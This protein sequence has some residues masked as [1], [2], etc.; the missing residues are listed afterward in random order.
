VL[1]LGQFVGVCV[2]E[3]V[4]CAGEFWGLNGVSVC[5]VWENLVWVCGSEC[6]LCEAQFGGFEGSECE[7]CVGQFV[8][9][10]WE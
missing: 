9:G 3:C 10:L 2:I 6:V 5:C 7:L 8:L 4:L 1:C